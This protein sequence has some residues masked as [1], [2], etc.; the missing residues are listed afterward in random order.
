MVVETPDAVLV[1]DRARSQ[2]VKA[3]VE[4]L[5]REGRGEHGDPAAA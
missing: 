3:I 5:A 4:R 1:I 2:Q